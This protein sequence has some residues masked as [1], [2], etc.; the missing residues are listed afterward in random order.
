MGLLSL[1]Q[2]GD[3]A[4]AAGLG[5]I[6]SNTFLLILLLRTMSVNKS[7]LT[8][9]TVFGTYFAEGLQGEGSRDV[10]QPASGKERSPEG[11]ALVGVPAA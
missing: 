2:G 11:A 9:R 6:S 3:P 8:L 10:F 5:S 4:P 7:P 1:T